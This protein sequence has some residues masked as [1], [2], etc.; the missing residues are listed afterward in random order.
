M[1]AN[2]ASTAAIVDGAERSRGCFA[3]ACRRDWSPRDG[4]V[5]TRGRMAAGAERGG[6]S[7]LGLDTR[8][9]WYLTRGT[10]MV[11]LMLL[12]LTLVLGVAA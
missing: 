9:L 7:T 1:A 4:A 6:V 2:T 12:T 5:V 11:T 8:T 3:R 10:G